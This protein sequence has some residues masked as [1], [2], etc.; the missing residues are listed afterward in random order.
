MLYKHEPEKI[1]AKPTAVAA[2]LVGGGSTVSLV[3]FWKDIEH[4]C[5]ELSKVA[6]C[7]P[8][9]LPAPPASASSALWAVCG[10]AAAAA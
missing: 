5:A 6:S 4:S 2:T 3:L 9:L 8:S 10:T 7:C 1:G